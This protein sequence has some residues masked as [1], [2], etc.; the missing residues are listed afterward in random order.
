MKN[1]FFCFVLFCS[2]L[3]AVGQSQQGFNYQTIVRDVAGNV[4]AHAEI[5]L[6]I[7]IRAVAPD[8][9]IVYGEIHE[10]ITNASGLVNLIIGQGNPISGVFKD[11]NWSNNPHFFEIA[12]DIDKSGQFVSIG[13][14]QF[15]SVPYS[16]H[17]DISAGLQVLTTEERD[18]IENP[19]AGM[20]IFN[21]STKCLNYFGGLTWFET[22][23]DCTPLPS[24]A[25]AG[26]DQV[27]LV[28]DTSTYLNANAPQFGTG[29]W[30]ILSGEGA[31]VED[32]N[33]ANTFFTGLSC[34][35]YLLQWTI[36][37]LCGVT[38][39]EVNIHF[40]TTPT[41][42]EAGEDQWYVDGTWTYLQG[43]VPEIGHGQWSILLGD[44]GNIVE[45]ANPASLFFGLNNEV[46]RL[47]WEISTACGASTDSV[48][49]SFGFGM[50]CG[51]TNIIDQRDGNHYPTIQIGNQCW[52][53]QNLAYLPAVSGA[54]S[55]STSS[56]RYYVYDYQGTNVEDAKATANYQTYGTLYNW[57]AAMNA[58]PAGWHLP[59]DA[60]F[61]TLAKF[62]D[63]SV[64]C[65]TTSFSGTNAGGKMKTTGTLQNGDGLWQHPNSGA[66][67]ESNFSTLPG[68]R[69]AP[70]SQVF[71]N[72]GYYG[73]YWSS[74]SNGSDRWG[75]ILNNNEARI[76]RAYGTG[77]HGF[78]V[79][80]VKN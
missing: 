74:S 53:K 48:Y 40:N 61:C 23:G 49:V 12:F 52:M 51:L 6:Q 54:S 64:N 19:V 72:L 10:A 65:G 47:V 43:N 78:M 13:V 75:W 39:D 42:A 25:D 16:R 60:E 35:S 62:I 71:D 14:S 59:T 28:D 77:D 67:N 76:Q 27:I 4:M 32:I 22:C 46:Y 30:S 9:E 37:N 20:Q 5:S 41:Q 33:D 3:S 8:G 18:A 26:A 36:E 7:N 58:C 70:T 73:N 21:S 68:G 63:P 1:H 45:P 2:V 17:S 11:I 56:P 57:P 29:V 44:G 79:R 50:I 66:T 15:L 80:C 55:G 34:E 31:V 38:S 69:R 24:Q